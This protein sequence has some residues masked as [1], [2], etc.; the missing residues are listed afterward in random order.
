MF[1]TALKEAMAF[2]LLLCSPAIIYAAIK[3][4]KGA[5]EDIKK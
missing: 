3:L 4:A 1:I 5:M 2:G